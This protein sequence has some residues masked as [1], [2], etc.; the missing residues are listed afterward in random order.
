MT[1]EIKCSGSRASTAGPAEHFTGAVPAT[2]MSHVAIAEALGGSSVTWMGK[3]T[4][5]QYGA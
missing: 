5:E 2:A 1:M 3:V 4:D